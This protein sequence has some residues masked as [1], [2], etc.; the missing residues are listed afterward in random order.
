VE[1][2]HGK[3]LLYLVLIGTRV[4]SRRKVLDKG[5]RELRSLEGQGIKMTRIC[6]GRGIKDEGSRG[7]DNFKRPDKVFEVEVSFQV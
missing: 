3:K 2:F 6:E 1:L 5:L 4:A 7:Q